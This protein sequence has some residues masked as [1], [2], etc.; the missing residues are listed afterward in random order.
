MRILGDGG[1]ALGT[2][3]AI[4][5]L[6]G[7]G[8]TAS[9]AAAAEQVADGGFEQTT[10][11]T[12]GFS[13]TNPSWAEGGTQSFVCN[14]PGCSTNTFNFPRTGSGWLQLGGDTITGNTEIGTLT[15][16]QPL[17]IPRA[18]A[19]LSYWVRRYGASDHVFSEFTVRIDGQEVVGS[20]ITDP[21]IGPVSPYQKFTI[22]L[23][24]NVGP[25]VRTL[26]LQ[27][28]CGKAGSAAA[29]PC[30]VFLVDDV[31]VTVPDPPVTNP[32]S[33]NP[34]STS[35]PV[36]ET[37]KTCRKGFKLK[38]GKCKRKKRKKKG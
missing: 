13:C 24:P 16:T 2:A 18:P 7:V 26:S 23:S 21:L 32:P 9:P 5:V 17:L 14:T 28:E 34:P 1:K 27:M 33:T 11:P 8:A 4:A 6:V 25:A 15:M 29:A 31:S 37:P 30:D 20:K 3:V 38:K 10:C 36:T 12:D 19:S 35:T 22:D